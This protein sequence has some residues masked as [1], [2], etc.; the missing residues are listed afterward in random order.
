MFPFQPLVSKESERPTVVF[1]PFH[2]KLLLQ[3]LCLFSTTLGAQSFHPTP[4]PLHTE[5][6]AFNLAN[7]CYL[8][9]QNPSG[10]SLLLRWRRL[11]VGMPEG[12]TVDLCDYGT[13]YIGIP[14]N[15][16]MN[17]VYDTTQPYLKLVVQPG[18]HA[19]AAWFW[20][21]VFELDNESNFQDVYFSLH[22]PGTTA[23]PESPAQT[24]VRFYPNPV[25]DV[26]HI[27]HRQPFEAPA[28]LLDMQGRPLWEG[29]L[30]AN[31]TTAVPTQTLPKGVYCLQVGERGYKVVL[32]F[33]F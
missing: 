18:N 21:R 25:R 20:F 8:H 2:F 11:E 32:S 5:E 3:V 15:G 13:C 1:S 26:L 23:I 31:G 30:P 14:P 29:L 12:W 33:G 16:I 6:V 4:A 22:T 9:F 19:G 7:E 28:R 17:I 24:P 10:D 27:D